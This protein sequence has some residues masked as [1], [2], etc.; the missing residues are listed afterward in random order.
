[1]LSPTQLTLAS[2]STSPSTA[3]PPR[4]FISRLLTS[5]RCR[6][7]VSPARRSSLIRSLIARVAFA[8]L[9][10]PRTHLLNHFTFTPR[11]F[12]ILSIRMV[13][14]FTTIALLASALFPTV[15]AH[16]WVEAIAVDGQIYAGPAPGD[17]TNMKSP[18]RQVANNGPT[19]GTDNT[20]LAC[21]I[22]AHTPASMVVP[23]NPG[24]RIT[25]QWGNGQGGK[26][27]HEI[28]PEMTYLA[29]CGGDCT[30]FDA[31]KAEWFKVDQ[32]GQSSSGWYQKDI[33]TSHNF[34]FPSAHLQSTFV[35]TQSRVIR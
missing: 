32:A 11:I 31:T 20:D 2:T 5:P 18:I 14:L 15:A 12:L 23:A 1:V 29:D 35:V 9:S 3:R 26:W 6:S 10:Q 16:G 34:P 28:G 17:S 21:G 33:R 4:F 22:G 27:V 19:K 30:T 7:S 8:H 24:S 13:H 25:F